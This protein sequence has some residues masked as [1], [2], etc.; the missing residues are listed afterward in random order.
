[1]IV[2]DKEICDFCGTCVAV[3]RPDAIFL[4]ERDIVIDREKC[5]ECENCIVVCPVGAVRGET[6]E[7]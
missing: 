3:C 7:G 2:I 6:G 4:T 1:M 5:T